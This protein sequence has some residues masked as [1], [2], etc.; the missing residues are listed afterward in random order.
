MAGSR[1]NKSHVQ[2]TEKTVHFAPMK[3]QTNSPD[4]QKLKDMILS[5]AVTN[6]K[7]SQV[8]AQDPLFMQYDKNNFRTNLNELKASLGATSNCEF[9]IFIFCNVILYVTLDN[10]LPNPS[11]V[12]EWTNPRTGEQFVDVIVLWF[13]RSAVRIR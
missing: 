10:D 6:M 1:G 7:T 3:W 5:G 9:I 2:K 11:I 4:A 13:H 12:T 8:W